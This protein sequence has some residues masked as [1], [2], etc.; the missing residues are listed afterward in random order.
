MSHNYSKILLSLALLAIVSCKTRNFGS[1][2]K[3]SF[4]EAYADDT[5]NVNCTLDYCRRR[6]LS[7]D[8]RRMPSERG[9]YDAVFRR[10]SGAVGAALGASSTLPARYPLR[11]DFRLASRSSRRSLAV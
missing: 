9:A 11:R 10:V 8:F 3:N 7:V 4:I 1:Q 5:V 6:S 2:Q